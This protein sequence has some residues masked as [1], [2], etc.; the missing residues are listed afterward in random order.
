L[1]TFAGSHEVARA[2]MNQAQLTGRV[3]PHILEIE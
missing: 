2:A 1:Y 3:A